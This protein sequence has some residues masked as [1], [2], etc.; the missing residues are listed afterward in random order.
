MENVDPQTVYGFVYATPL[1]ESVCAEA[2][3]FNV[4]NRRGFAWSTAN[5]AA[6]CTTSISCP[7]IVG[8]IVSHR[9][10]WLIRPS[11]GGLWLADR[12]ASRHPGGVQAVAVDGAVHWFENEVDTAVWRAVASRAGAE[13]GVVN[14]SRRSNCSH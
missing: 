11:P 7:T 14:L 1:T 3:T 6:D 12:A 4:N 13:A 5:T 9:G 2:R 8:P 10:W